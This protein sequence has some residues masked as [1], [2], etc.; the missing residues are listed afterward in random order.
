MASTAVRIQLDLASLLAH[1][2]A[3]FEKAGWER[4]SEEMGE[5][6]AFSGW[7][8]VDQEGRHW[9]GVLNVLRMPMEEQ[10]YFVQAQASVTDD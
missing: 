8:I 9:R 10:E 7:T 6:Q 2:E 4:R 5:S 3:Q 1:Y